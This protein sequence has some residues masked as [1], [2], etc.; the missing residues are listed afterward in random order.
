MKHVLLIKTGA[1][2][3][4]ILFSV[5]IDIAAKIFHNSEISLLT[6]ENYAEIYRDCPLIKQIFT[7]PNKKN[8]FK[9][10]KIMMTIRT[11]NYDVTIDL[12]GNLKTNFFT[13]LIG[14]RQRIGLYKKQLGKL[15]LTQGI[16]KATGLDPINSQLKFWKQVTGSSISGYLQV[17]ISNEKRKDFEK[18]LENYGLEA[19][20]YIVF[21]PAA[22]TQWQTKLWLTD[23]WVNLGNSLINKG[24]SIVLVGDKHARPINS[25]IASQIDGKIIDISGQTSFSDL[26][27]IIENAKT[28]ITTDSGPMHL[29]AAT[30]TFTVAIFGPTDPENHCPPGI[31]SVRA[32]NICPPCYQKRCSHHS[33]MRQI[34]ADIIL[35]LLSKT[36]LK[37]SE[38]SV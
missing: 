20:K 37:I 9:F 36:I 35:N 23:H 33:C 26:A 14:S 17:W 28:I 3:D 11:R 5:S 32:K 30:R 25:K 38:D 22:S 7:L 16:K 18:F 1:F 2:G 13:F 29:A 34:D 8:I 19:K 27:L 4:M 31:V 12:Q 15:L 21:H 24:F 6:T 10:T